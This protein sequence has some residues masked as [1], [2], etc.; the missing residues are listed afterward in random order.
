MSG[1]LESIVAVHDHVKRQL[2]ST[3][4][5]NHPPSSFINEQETPE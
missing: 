3:F 2:S 5:F 4:D 1:D